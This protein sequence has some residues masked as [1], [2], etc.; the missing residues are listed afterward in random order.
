MKFALFNKLT[1]KPGQSGRVVELLI[2]SGQLFNDN[3]AC[4]LYLV[5]ES[6]DDPNVVWVADLWT[7]EQEH[8]DALKAPELRPYIEE[9]IPLLERMPEQIAVR[10]MGGKWSGG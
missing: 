6:T 1:A 4:I 9:T 5:A 10:P 7:S 8:S 3:P 2:E